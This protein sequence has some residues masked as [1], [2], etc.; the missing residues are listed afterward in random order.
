MSIILDGIGAQS[1]HKFSYYTP[2]AVS[3]L[4]PPCGPRW[5]GTQ[6]T[7][8]GAHLPTGRTVVCRFDDVLVPAVAITSELLNCTAP[9]HAPG[10]VKVEVS[11]DG[12]G[13]SSSTAPFYY[14][15]VF[16][17]GSLLSL[18]HI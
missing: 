13:T 7:V 18:I 3:A 1:L 12:L 2:P 17:L 5:G 9:A 8:R 11:G 10:L 6:I 14:H 15:D 4:V 16:E